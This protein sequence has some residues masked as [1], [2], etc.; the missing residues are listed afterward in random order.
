MVLFEKRL[1]WFWFNFDNFTHKKMSIKK[2]HLFS[3]GTLQLEKVQ[4]ETYG[5]LLTGSTDKL[6]NYKLD[7]LR[8][9]DKDVL[10]KSGKEFHPIAL[11]TNNSED[12]IEG[13]V[14]EITEEELIETDKYE[15]SDYIRVLETFVSGKKAW[16]YVA[17]TE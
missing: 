3:Y 4:I 15:V 7:K 10:E 16:I 17:N 14:F 5:R 8:I 6:E 13:T 12:F 2:H 1:F 11:K 9:T